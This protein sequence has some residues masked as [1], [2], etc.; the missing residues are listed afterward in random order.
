MG[1]LL[2]TAP[3]E[4]QKLA[5]WLLKLLPEWACTWSG[6]LV[7]AAERHLVDLLDEAHPQRLGR[8]APVVEFCELREPGLQRT[9][10]HPAADRAL[11]HSPLSR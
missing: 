3:D 6:R 10:C 1:T 5:A 7:P 9:H 2:T 4:K 8:G 11:E